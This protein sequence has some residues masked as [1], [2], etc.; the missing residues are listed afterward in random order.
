MLE[1]HNFYR[2]NHKVNLLKLDKKLAK[3]AVKYLKNP[4]G[5]VQLP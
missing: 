1:R 4:D 2:S 3:D 5:D